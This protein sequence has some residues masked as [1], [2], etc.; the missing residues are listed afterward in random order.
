M[1]GCTDVVIVC[2]VGAVAKPLK[3]GRS[4]LVAFAPHQ[5]MPMPDPGN[6]S[7]AN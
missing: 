5:L 7:I 3:Q 2:G 6:L 4:L 1:D